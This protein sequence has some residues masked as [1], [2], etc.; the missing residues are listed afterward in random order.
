MTSN[1]TF[2]VRFTTPR[3]HFYLS[4]WSLRGDHDGSIGTTTL[5]DGSVV[6]FGIVAKEGI[7]WSADRN[8]AVRFANEESAWVARDDVA[9]ETTNL[10]SVSA[11]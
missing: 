1:Q 6:P 7:A 4:T 8:A 11:V 3:G 5:P 9:V 10:V 2:F